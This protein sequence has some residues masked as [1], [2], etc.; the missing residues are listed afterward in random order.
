[1]IFEIYIAFVVSNVTYPFVL[2]PRETI[3][4]YQPKFIENSFLDGEKTLD[5]FFIGPTIGGYEPFKT[6]FGKHIIIDIFLLVNH[7]EIV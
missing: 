2:S 4:E 7:P 6:T 3:I 1:M 5:M